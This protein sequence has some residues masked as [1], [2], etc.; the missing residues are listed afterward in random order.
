MVI[1]SKELNAVL[2]AMYPNAVVY[3]LDREFISRDQLFY[4]DSLKGFRRFMTGFG[5]TKW[6]AGKMDCDKWAWLFKAYV[7]AKAYFSKSLYASPIGFITYFI[8]G[9]PYNGHAINVAIV[10]RAGFLDV[11]EIDAE[12]GKGPLT[13]T[14]TERAS[15]KL[16]IF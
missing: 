10:V 6:V 12:P 4:T 5:I 16:V 9:K 3:M 13:L 7:I 2:G 14:K 8:E 11:F 1:S 15:V